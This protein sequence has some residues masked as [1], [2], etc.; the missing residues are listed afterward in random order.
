MQFYEEE[1]YR[2]TETVWN[3]IVGLEIGRRQG[4]LPEQ[5]DARFLTGYVQIAGAWHGAFRL[6]CSFS[7]AR[8]IAAIM[9]RFETT[10][11]TVDDIRDALGEMANITGGN[12]KGLLPEPCRLALPVVVVD[13]SDYALHLPGSRILTQI[14]L[15]CEQ[16]PFR[17]TLLS[18]PKEPLFDNKTP[19]VGR[20]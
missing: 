17:V 13:G 4:P 11:T 2:I 6:D 18:L 8:R 5:S 15:E 16:E 9:F 7:L 1:I 14:N 20:A 10:Q 12:V 3:S 19:G